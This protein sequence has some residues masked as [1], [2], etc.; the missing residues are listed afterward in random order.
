MKIIKVSFH[1]FSGHRGQQEL[2]L[3]QSV[4]HVAVLLA[5]QEHLDLGHRHLLLRALLG[6]QDDADA[7]IVEEANSFHHAQG[8][9]HWAV[10]VVLGE[11][12][13]LQELVLDDGGSL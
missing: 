2:H 3:V 13:L 6:V 5:R 11:R 4:H 7:A 12:V 1:F 9:V 10:V 8:L